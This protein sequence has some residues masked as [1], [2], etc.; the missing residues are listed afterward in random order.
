MTTIACRNGILAADTACKRYEMRGTQSKIIRTD[1]WIIGG[2]GSVVDVDMLVDW[3][4]NNRKPTELPKFVCYG[5]ERPN[6]ALLALRNDGTLWFGNHWG[7]ADML[8]DPFWA[9]GSGA[10]AAMAAMH[11]GA[12]ARRAVEI[13]ALVDPQTGGAVEVAEFPPRLRLSADEYAE[14]RDGLRANEIRHHFVQQNGPG[15]NGN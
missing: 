10:E 7:Q 9:I 6:A 13:A 1:E 12:D 14:I 2:A 15:F 8:R 4:I 11:M 3:F 5:D